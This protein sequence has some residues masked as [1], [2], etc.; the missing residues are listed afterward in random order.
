MDWIEPDTESTASVAETTT[1]KVKET[2]K[3][4]T[5]GEADSDDEDIDGY[6]VTESLTGGTLENEYSEPDL[7]DEDIRATMTTTTTVRTYYS[8]Q[9]IS[10]T[11][12]KKTTTTTGRKTT[13]AAKTTT[14]ETTTT[15]TTTTTEAT[16][17]AFKADALYP[18][19]DDKAYGFDVRFQ[20]MSDTTYLNLRYGPSKS[21]DVQV[22]IP[23]G[24]TVSG[25][26]ETTDSDGNSWVYVTY[27]GTSGW[28]MKGLLGEIN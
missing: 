25:S 8:G 23:N 20:V 27:N 7:Y 13:T 3:T 12:T 5:Y 1:P 21:Y 11:T 28:V 16:T 22:K 2:T 17:T 26:G 6:S 9:S 18:L 15:T 19:T 10:T 14:A 4:A 24:E